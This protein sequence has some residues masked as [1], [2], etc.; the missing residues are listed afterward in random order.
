MASDFASLVGLAR[1]AVDAVFGE[2]AR[3]KPMDRAKGPHG[4]R[5]ASTS[6]SEQTIVVA[7]FTNIEFEASRRAQP[8]IGQTGERML[9]RSPDLIGS[10]GFAG[11]IAVEDRLRRETTGELFEVLWRDRDGFGN[12]IVGLAAIKGS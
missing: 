6:R 1:D 11:E 7:F 2:D 12:T 9:N 8:T 4:S 5:P 3:L 10:T